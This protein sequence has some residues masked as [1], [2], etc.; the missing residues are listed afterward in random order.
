MRHCSWGQTLPA[1]ACNP[2]Q[3]VDVP[4]KLGGGVIGV[5][6]EPSR[7]SRR[8]GTLAGMWGLMMVSVRGIRGLAS[9]AGVSRDVLGCEKC[10]A[11]LAGSCVAMG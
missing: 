1:A 9:E 3:D 5:P 10:D 7:S 2:L 6:V 8:T 11:S 4:M